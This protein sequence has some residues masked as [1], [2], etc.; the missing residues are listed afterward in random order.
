MAGKFVR[1][2]VDGVLRPVA[3]L[4]TETWDGRDDNGRMCLNGRY[5][6]QIQIEDAVTQNQTIYSIA[7][8]R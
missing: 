7:L 5:L 1:T 2:V 4:N 8:V 3:V 6:L